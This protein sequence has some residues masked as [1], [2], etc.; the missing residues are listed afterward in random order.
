MQ[1]LSVF[2][3]VTKEIVLPVLKSLSVKNQHF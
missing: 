1:Y 3:V 2:D